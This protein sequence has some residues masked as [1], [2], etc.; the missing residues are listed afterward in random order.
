MAKN[1]VFGPILAHIALIRAAIFFSKIWL[2]QSLDN[3]VIYRHV[4]Y[5][6]K[7]IIQS[8]E[9]LVTDGRTGR[10]TDR[11]DWFHRTL[12]LTLCVQQSLSWT[13][14]KKK[15]HEIWWRALSFWILIQFYY[16]SKSYNMLIYLKNKRI[17]FIG[18]YWQDENITV[19]FLSFS[20]L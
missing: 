18:F 10:L 5:Q 1:L 16:I 14:F 6:E 17:S 9:N 7:L 11:R 20:N 13:S 4:Q 8:W 3:M 12:H 2:R 19:N 15:V